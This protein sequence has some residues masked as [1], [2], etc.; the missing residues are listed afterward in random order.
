MGTEKALVQPAEL[1]IQTSQGR[2]MVGVTMPPETRAKQQ[3]YPKGRTLI[4]L[5]V[6]METVL[7]T[8]MTGAILAV[9]AG[10]LLVVH[11]LLLVLLLVV[12]VHRGILLRTTITSTPLLT[13]LGFSPPSLHTS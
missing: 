6:M 13:L 4:Y 1:L 8:M 9:A 11:L 10:V 2:R 5:R 3:T 12:R 7:A